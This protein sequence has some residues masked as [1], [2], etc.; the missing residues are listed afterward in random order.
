MFNFQ[1]IVFIL[2][3]T[4]LVFSCNKNS[5]NT[6]Q[7]KVPAELAAQ[8]ISLD[9]YKDPNCGC[10]SKWID[11]MED[12]AFVVKATDTNDLARIKQQYKI[13]GKY[14]SCHTGISKEGYV[15]E[16][17]VPAKYVAQFLAEKPKGAI[18]LTVPS[19]PVGTPGMEVGNKFMPY[20]IFML[21]EQGEALVYADIKNYE[22]QF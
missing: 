14:Q 7:E 12:N 21:M 18:G 5:N 19:M 9:V 22:E 8:T 15:F 3:F 11:H 17:H 4:G 16:G 2:L 20:K 1:K 10:C 6:A 13:E